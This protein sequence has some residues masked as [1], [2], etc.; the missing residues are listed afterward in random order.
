[1]TTLNDWYK[2]YSD[3]YLLKMMYDIDSFDKFIV[4]EKLPFNKNKYL[5][6]YIGK[7]FQNV[8][9]TY[10][11]YVCDELIN[12]LMTEMIMTLTAPYVT[13][14]KDVISDITD[15]THYFRILSKHIKKEK[16]NYLLF[17]EE[18]KIEFNLSSD[19]IVF[20]LDKHMTYDNVNIFLNEE[21]I[22]LHSH[23]L[24]EYSQELN[25]DESYKIHFHT[26]NY[27][28]GFQYTPFLKF[29]EEYL[30]YIF[31]NFGVDSY[32]G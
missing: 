13:S 1:M 8:F 24:N 26:V 7:I 30:N 4:W 27:D 32:N 15:Y 16:I 17:K 29:C 14:K 12:Y 3:K 31:K 10:D 6:F 19:D 18:Q 22:R 9:N 11:V 2:Y 28:K 21:Y 20:F 23:Y 25:S 5:A